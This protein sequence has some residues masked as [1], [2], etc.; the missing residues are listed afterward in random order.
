[1][2]SGGERSGDL[3]LELVRRI[4]GGDREAWDELYL[5]YHD[6]LLLAIRARLGSRLRA[7]LESE[8]I[9]H[10]V[11]KDALRDLERFEPR[12]P[13]ALGH[14]LHVCVLNKI[15]S[16]AEFHGAE[17]RSGEETLSDSLLA[18][19]PGS[20]ANEPRYLDGERFER[21]ERALAR[22]P[23][24]LREVVLLRTVEG[25]SNQEAA[26]VLGKT[27]EAASKLFNRA[28]ARLGS[29]VGPAG[30]GAG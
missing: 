8:D 2:E 16:K 11:V 27:P 29:L 23:E 10:S 12:G 24:N 28:L 26:A 30:G 22:L 17:R 1:M 21:L 3:S 13:G 6:V 4:H 5:R 25:L 18:R 15:R 20:A 19:L 7:R 14:Y 9:L